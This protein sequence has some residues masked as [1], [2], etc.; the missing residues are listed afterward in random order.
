VPVEAIAGCLRAIGIRFIKTNNRVG[1]LATSQGSGRGR[2]RSSIGGKGQP[3]KPINANWQAGFL[4]SLVGPAEFTN[5]QFSIAHLANRVIGGR[6]ALKSFIAKQKAV[7]AKG[8][9]GRN[10]PPARFIAR[11]KT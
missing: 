4:L 11:E 6:W 9:V 10:Q 2:Q 7:S 1:G 5:P 3:N 8:S